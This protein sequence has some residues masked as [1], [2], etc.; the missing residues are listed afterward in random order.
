MLVCPRCEGRVPAGRARC[1]RCGKAV[2]ESPGAKVEPRASKRTV[3]VIAGACVAVGGIA[4][5]VMSGSSETAS[6]PAIAATVPSSSKAAPVD[7]GEP[8]SGT[9]QQLV[10][11]DASRAGALA[12]KSGDVASALAQF[13]SAIEADPNNAESLNNLGQ[14]LV[15][16]GRAREALPYFDRAI[17]EA[18]G[19]WSYHFNRARAYAELR[20]WSEAI[21]G[22]NDA[23]R[24]FPDDYVTHFN[25]AKARQ[26][27]GDVPGAVESYAKAI[28]L[29]PEQ[30]DFYLWHAQALDMAGRSGEAAASYRKFLE[31]QPNEPR[32]EKVQARLL[33]L[34][35]VAP[36]ASPVAR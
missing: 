13:T 15:R 7:G 3:L 2:T 33:Q 29:A 22:Y 5:A 20:E 26:A 12:Y 18:G 30:A 35:G 28:E 36:G 25:L 14:V 10:S 32:A 8:G 6:R 19:V 27:G 1:G 4:V 34:T 9:A 24:L 31:M 11:A 23:L 21:T 17:A 16:A